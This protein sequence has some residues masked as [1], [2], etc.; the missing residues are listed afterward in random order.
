[1]KLTGSTT[2][3]MITYLLLGLICCST[4]KGVKANELK[5][6]AREKMRKDKAERQ[7]QADNAGLVFFTWICLYH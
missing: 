4:I 6:R 3:T 2:V 7:L 5:L 1:M